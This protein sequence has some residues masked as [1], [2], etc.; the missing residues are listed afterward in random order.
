MKTRNRLTRLEQ[1]AGPDDTA[2][3]IQP[4]TEQQVGIMRAIFRRLH[5]EQA[6]EYD[7]PSDFD[8]SDCDPF[9]NLEGEEYVAAVRELMREAGLM[10]EGLKG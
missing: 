1:L 4:T 6:W 5:A 9:P 3:L 10:R 8:P 7:D 2:H